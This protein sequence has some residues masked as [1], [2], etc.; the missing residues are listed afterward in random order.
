M[1]LLLARGIN[2]TGIDPT[3]EGD[4]ELVIKDYYSEKYEY[5]KVNNFKAHLRAYTATFRF[6]YK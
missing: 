4:S 5:L 6:F 3:Y 1:D 2:I